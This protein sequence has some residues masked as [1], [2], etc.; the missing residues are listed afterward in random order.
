MFRFVKVLS[1]FSFALVVNKVL[2]IFIERLLK[3]GASMT[4][5]RLTIVSTE[6][7]RVR[8]ELKALGFDAKP[9]TVTRLVSE[10]NRLKKLQ[11]EGAEIVPN[12]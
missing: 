9:A 12:F 3:T 6:L 11:A 1:T 4:D 8:K 10:L 5:H 7:R 2:M